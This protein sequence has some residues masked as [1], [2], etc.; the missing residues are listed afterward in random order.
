MLL[1][2]CLN[3]ARAPGEHPALPVT[4]DELARDAAAAVAAGA[5]AVHV[6]PRGAG[7]TETLDP[8]VID[9]TVRVVRAACGVP[10]GVSTGAW[11]EPEPARR[12]ALV[13]AWREP[14]FASVNLSEPGHREVM[15]A[16]AAGVGI[17]AGVGTV[18][19]VAALAETGF[20]GR[21]V[22]VLVEP[23][24]ED[25]EAAVTRAAAIDAALDA[26]GIGAP[27]VHHGYGRATWPVLEQAVRRGRGIRAGL[28]DALVLPGGEPAPDNA[29]LVAAAAA[30]LRA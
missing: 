9:A 29:A 26:A 17:E 8:A 11:I 16:L 15:A 14:D 4:A 5:A 25:A 12:A 30:L 6:H 18:E 1:K 21:L 20:A 2:A 28:E 23:Q 3:G 22:R 10:V 24:D 7:G 19:D 13:A 27:R